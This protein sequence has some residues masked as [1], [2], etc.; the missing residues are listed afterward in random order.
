MK[1]KVIPIVNRV[2]GTVPRELESGLEELEI[3]GQAEFTQ[4]QAL[5]RSARIP[6]RVLETRGDL[7]SFRLQWM[8]IKLTLVW[9]EVDNNNNNNNN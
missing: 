9:K 5:L 6:R 2:L 7:L 8:T 3:R 4:T 1:L